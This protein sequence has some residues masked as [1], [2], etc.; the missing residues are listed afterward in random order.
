MQEIVLVSKD[1]FDP[2][3]AIVPPQA[4]STMDLRFEL[5]RLSL[6]LFSSKSTVG[7]PKILLHLVIEGISVS[8]YSESKP[9]YMKLQ[10]GLRHLFIRDY[11][12]P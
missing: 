8:L 4:N 10:V 2:S 5:P 9:E 1:K 6:Q 11:H 12:S 7:K 3:E